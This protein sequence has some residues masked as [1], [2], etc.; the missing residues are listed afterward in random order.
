MIRLYPSWPGACQSST[1][2]ERNRCPF[3]ATQP[4]LV[5]E[6]WTHIIQDA[7]ELCLDRGM[8]IGRSVNFSWMLEVLSERFGIADDHPINQLFFKLGK[9][10]LVVGFGWANSDGIHGW[11]TPMET[12]E[13]AEQLEPL[14]LP[15]YEPTIER[16]VQ[17]H[18]ETLR[19]TGGPDEQ[20]KLQR[21]W[22]RLSLSF[23]R[24]VA[25]I[26]VKD[27]K[28]ML[29]GNDIAGYLIR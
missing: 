26:A 11:L 13:L 15:R 18:Q 7:M 5:S 14:A 9:R 10:G 22:E 27:N 21:D 29:W 12:R 25:T 20:I 4:P 28:G 2:P 23:V 19:P 1:C 24:T 8:F 6:A 16:M 17:L 3:H